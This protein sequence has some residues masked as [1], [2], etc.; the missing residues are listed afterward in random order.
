MPQRAFRSFHPSKA[1][2]L[3]VACGIVT[4]LL[5]ACRPDVDPDLGSRPEASDLAVELAAYT[6]GIERA[7]GVINLAAQT[8]DEVLPTSEHGVAFA[9]PDMVYI[10]SYGAL[11]E[12]LSLTRT[13]DGDLAVF[14]PGD[15]LWAAGAAT[16]ENVAKLV[17]APLEI[18]LLARALLAEPLAD[19][20][21][22]PG[23]VRYVGETGDDLTRLAFRR[24]DGSRHLLI[25]LDGAAPVPREQ[26]LYDATGEPVLLVMYSDY[27]EIDG[28][29]RPEVVTLD[30][31]KGSVVTVEFVEQELNPELPSAV[32][33]LAPP[34]DVRVVDL[35]AYEPSTE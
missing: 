27:S 11:G 34:P 32:F 29:L 18:G 15:N 8:P 22:Y 20:V 19:V 9:R 31:L 14:F 30:D 2:V 7:K 3:G 33:D 17:G 16:A 28:V 24:P 5:S 25:T 26:Q 13:A 10:E 35:D 12:I 6:A 21:D 1:T 4:A 23:S